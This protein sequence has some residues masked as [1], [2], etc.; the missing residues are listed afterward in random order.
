MAKNRA[1]YLIYNSISSIFQQII[2]VICGLLVPRMI[3]AAYGSAVNGTISSIAQFI[4]I[5]SLLQGGVSGATRVA[6]YKPVAINN[7]DGINVVYSTSQ[8]FFR[9]FSVGLAIYIFGLSFVYPLLFESAFSVKDTLYMVLILGLDAVFNY[10][11]GITNQLLLF[12]DQRGYINTL[13]QAFCTVLSAACSLILISAGASIHMVKLSSALV[14]LIRPFLL[15][16]FVKRKFKIEKVPRDPNVLSQSN[17]AL[18]KSVAFHIHTSTDSIIITALMSPV[19]VS[20]Y[21][22]HKYVV[23]S[24]S[25]I[26]STVLGNTEVVFGQM[27]ANNEKET[28]KRE[29]PVYDL[30][31][32]MFSTVFFFTC[33]ILISQFVKIYTRNVEDISY[34]HPLFAVLLCVS[35][36]VYCMS[37]TYHNIIMSSG[38]IKQTRWISISE[39]VSNIVLSIMLVRVLGIE[40]VAIGTI[41]AFLFNTIAN[42]HYMKN[43]IFNMSIKFIVKSYVVNLTAG[44]LAIIIFWYVIGYEIKGFYDF[45]IY[46]AVVFIVVGVIDVILNQVFLNQY[47]GSVLRAIKRKITLKH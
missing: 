18:V 42:I 27:I 40:G 26:V 22:V 3:L 43:N 37:L 44:V 14:L 24:I 7:H 35:E 28:L 16:V 1:K 4:S 2:A 25:S 13:L 33:I 36:M 41:V 6:F 8:N 17:A 32:K 31:S 46:A 19:W 34:Y 5:T 38:H 47:C 20:I 39:A 9:K 10:F 30:M 15:K 29:V 21:A 23:G 45:F 12:A 11:F